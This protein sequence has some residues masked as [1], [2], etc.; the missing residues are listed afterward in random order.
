VA[1]ETQRRGIGGALMERLLGDAAGRT[2][3]LNSTAEGLALYTRLGFVAFGHV[4][5]HQAI[6]SG[7]P[8][9]APGDRVRPFGEA[10]RQA[11]CQLDLAAAGMDRRVLIDALLAE[12]DFQV[13]E[14]GGSVAGFG[15]VRRWGRGVV[16]GPVVAFDVADAGALIAALATRHVGCFV[17]IDVPSAAGL[18]L[19]LETIGL[20]QVGQV[21]TMAR[22]DPPVSGD[23]PKLFALSNQSLG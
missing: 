11:V 14:R 3:V 9:I 19:W 7:V 20:P 6:L 13:I 1:A 10:D 2:I 15:C 16:I 5:Q 17:R 8:T 18:S 21:V 4:H 22:G 23:G 12:G